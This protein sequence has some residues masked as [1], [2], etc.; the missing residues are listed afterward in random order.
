MG[1][2]IIVICV[3]VMC[4][5]EMGFWMYLLV[6]WV[7]IVDGVDKFGLMVLIWLVMVNFVVDLVMVVVLVNI[8]FFVVVSGESKFRVVLYLLIII[9]LFVVIVLFIGLVFDWL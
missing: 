6:Y 8:L 2:W 7:V 3:V 9:V 4:S 5:C 1:E